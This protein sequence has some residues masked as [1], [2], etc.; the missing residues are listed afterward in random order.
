MAAVRWGGDCRP[1]RPA[2]QS[3]QLVVHH[4][5]PCG[6]R[7]EPVKGVTPPVEIVVGEVLLGADA[8]CRP[9]LL[10]VG[11]SP[12]SH[13]VKPWSQSPSRRR[14]ELRLSS[15][16]AWA[17]GTTK[18]ESD[19]RTKTATAV[20]HEKRDIGNPSRNRS[21]KRDQPRGRTRREVTSPH[22][23]QMLW[24]VSATSL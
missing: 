20:R 1:T 12:L 15:G 21:D 24:L 9:S 16:R 18:T 19:K 22:R 6:S 23:L 8:L 14:S 3:L 7:Q 10:P 11:R 13:A 4:R 17:V 2:N 5:L